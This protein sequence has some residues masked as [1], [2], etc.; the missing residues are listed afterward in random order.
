MY[1]KYILLH[2]NLLIQSSM[3]I[4][5]LPRNSTNQPDQTNP[6]TQIDCHKTPDERVAVF[7]F[8]FRIRG[9]G[10]K[11]AAVITKS[12]QALPS[13]RWGGGEQVVKRGFTRRKGGT[14]AIISNISIISIYRTRSSPP[15]ANI[16]GIE[17]LSLSCVRFHRWPHFFKASTTAC[18][19][20]GWTPY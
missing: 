1:I 12:N 17:S 3:K 14:K 9:G 19:L 13:F 11:T 8:G 5:G 7:P 15:I 16:N 6:S 20:N 10:P 18:V 4:T 2:L